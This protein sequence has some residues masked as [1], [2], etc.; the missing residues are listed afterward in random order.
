MTETS[1]LLESYA[2]ELTLNL[3]IV[4]GGKSCKALLEL[5]QKDLLPD[6][7]IN[8]VGVCDTNPEAE[9]L[10]MAK[11]LEIYTSDNTLI[12]FPLI[13]SAVSLNLPVVKIL[14][15]KLSARGRKVY[16]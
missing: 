4:G 10:K 6:L 15:C 1:E 9:G 2:Q 11:E 13:T 5:F 12:F 8:I 16:G 14:Y 7:T 3:A